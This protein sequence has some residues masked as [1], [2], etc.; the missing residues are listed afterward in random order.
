MPFTSSFFVYFLNASDCFKEP[1][2][3]V[4]YLICTNFTIAITS[5]LSRIFRFEIADA[6]VTKRKPIAQ[7]A[8][9][10]A[11]SDFIVKPH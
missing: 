1:K 3:P 5:G 10:K 2:V 7:P 8:I 11:D 9:I 6:N 4:R